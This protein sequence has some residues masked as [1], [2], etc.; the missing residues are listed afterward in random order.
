MVPEEEAQEEPQETESLQPYPLM[1]SPSIDSANLQRLEAY[2]RSIQSDSAKRGSCS[3]CQFGYCLVCIIVIAVILHEDSSD[4][5]T[6]IRLWLL[7]FAIACGAS[8]VAQLCFELTMCSDT[9]RN[10]KCMVR[11]IWLFV[12]VSFLFNLVWFILGNVWLYG[13][14]ECDTAFESGYITTLVILICY[15]IGYAAICCVCC[16][17]CCFSWIIG[18]ASHE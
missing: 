11:L 15:Y 12:F 8:I 13:D 3:S 14:P 17:I 7:V 4:C 5:E 6:P 16:C 10:S 18:M 9:V 1:R 2:A